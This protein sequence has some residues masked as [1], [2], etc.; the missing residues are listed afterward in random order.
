MD[1][2]IQDQINHLYINIPDLR[3]K[4]KQMESWNDWDAIEDVFK[5]GT[6]KFADIEETIK[7]KNRVIPDKGGCMWKPLASSV[8]VDKRIEYLYEICL[9]MAFKKFEP[10]AYR[11]NVNNKTDFGKYCVTCNIY[12]PELNIYQCPFCGR[13]LFLF[14]LD[15]HREELE[16]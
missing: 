14:P 8:E 1:I 2:V 12:T 4:L 10:E 16:S 15:N 3:D 9:E 13:K 6:W 11:E 7:Q 5:P